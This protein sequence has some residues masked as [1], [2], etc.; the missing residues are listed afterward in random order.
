MLSRKYDKYH[1]IFILDPAQIKS[2]PYFSQNAFDFMVESIM[3]VPNIVVYSG[4]PH[5]IIESLLEEASENDDELAFYVNADY[6]KYSKM[7]DSRMQ[8]VVDKYDSKMYSFDDIPLCPEMISANYKKFTPFYAGCCQYT[9]QDVNS[10][11]DLAAKLTP[12]TMCKD[13]I[14]N[15]DKIIDKITT[16]NKELKTERQKGGRQNG[17]YILQ[18]FDSKL[19]ET[20]RDDLSKETS[21]LSPHLK[22]GTISIRECYHSA[23]NEKFREELYW[24]DF[25]LQIANCNPRI[26]SRAFK[27]KY[28]NLQWI[29]SEKNK[30]FIAWCEGR[31]GFLIIDASMK[32]LNNTGYMPNRT[33]MICATFLTKDLHV[34]WQLGERYFATKLTDYDPSSNN[35]GWQWCA[36]TGADSTPY[37]RVFNPWTQQ[38]THDANCIFVKKNLPEFA[39]IP[40]DIILNWESEQTRESARKEYQQL[41]NYPEPIVDHYV[42]VEKTKEY[43]KT[44]L[45]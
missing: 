7:R 2:N 3:E 24:R 8:S 20:N 25:Y 21:R 6:T 14:E 17:L 33:R 27:E 44:V 36:S 11:E 38:K 23:Q 42:E 9:P 37:F 32:L 15:F 4:V 35:G 16:E 10:G 22:F 30:K 26:F 28:D 39:D 41:E 43:F 18:N 1:N 34:H 45:S 29:T 31:T 13:K 12:I 19:Y 40:N 5:E